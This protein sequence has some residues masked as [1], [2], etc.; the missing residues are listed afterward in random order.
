MDKGIWKKVFVNK[1]NNQLS[2]TISK[3]KL[4]SKKDLNL[5]GKFPKRIKLKIEDIEW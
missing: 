5:K 1:R 2:V 4:L 3:K